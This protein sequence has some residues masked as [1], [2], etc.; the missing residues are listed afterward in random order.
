MANLQQPVGDLFHL[1]HELIR[2]N[3]SLKWNIYTCSEYM[4]MTA[5]QLKY[6]SKKT[7][8][9]DIYTKCVD[10]VDLLFEKLRDIRCIFTF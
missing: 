7:K 8:Y 2:K 6:V 4:S 5:T 10:I 3:A 9:I 1:I